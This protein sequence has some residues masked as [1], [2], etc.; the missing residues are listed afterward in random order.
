MNFDINWLT[1]WLSLITHPGLLTATGARIDCEIHSKSSRK[2]EKLIN[3][4]DEHP[5]IVLIRDCLHQ[6][7]GDD[8]GRSVAGTILELRGKRNPPSNLRSE[9]IRERLKKLIISLSV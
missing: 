4:E 8:E 1:S 2:I 6:L 5:L 9:V 3:D 7:E